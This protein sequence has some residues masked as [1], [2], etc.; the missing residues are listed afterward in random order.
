MNINKEEFLLIFFSLHL[1]LFLQTCHF[2]E[3]RFLLIRNEIRSR[4]KR[5]IN[6]CENSKTNIA[7][8]VILYI[9][10]RKIRIRKFSINNYLRVSEC[11]T[12]FDY[13]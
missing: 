7:F 10:I 3:Y 1:H 4:G 9:Y 5:Q 8:S 13:V 6:H 2:I 11:I 12:D